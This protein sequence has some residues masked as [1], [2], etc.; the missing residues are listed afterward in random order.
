MFSLKDKHTLAL[1]THCKELVELRTIEETMQLNNLSDEVFI[2]GGGSNV[3]F[4]E[5]YEGQVIKFVGKS[6]T[7]QEKNEHWLVEAEA[8]VVWHHLVES[9]VHKG[10]PGL[11]NLALIPGNCGAAP[12]QNIGAYGSEFSRYCHQVFAVDLKS[13]EKLILSKNECHFGYRTSIFKEL[14]NPYLLITKIVLKLPKLWLAD[15][16]YRGLDILSAKATPQQVMDKVIE[17]RKSKLPEPEVLANAGSFFKN[18]IVNTEKALQLRQLYPDIP[19][20]PAP[21]NNTKLSA[22]WL[23]ENAGFK[24]KQVDN[25]GTYE[26]HALVLVNYGNASGANL[27]EFAR[28]IRDSVQSKFAIKLE[29]EVLIMGNKGLISL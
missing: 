13:K 7:I 18:P 3:G 5:D 10:I 20:Y 11:E 24:G 29:N 17:I 21:T 28:M 8:G 22:G 23:I 19:C 2:L 6:I 12:V 9:L 16:T 27:V 4:V 26:K 14:M 15:L 1:N 25:I